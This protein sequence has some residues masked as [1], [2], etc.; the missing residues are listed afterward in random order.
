MD[1]NN[2]GEI[3]IENL[4]ARFGITP[5]QAGDKLS[6]YKNNCTCA[7]SRITGIGQHGLP[8]DGFDEEMQDTTIAIFYKVICDCVLHKYL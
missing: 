2:I 3:I 5:E 4:Q 6:I 8:E 7:R 1:E